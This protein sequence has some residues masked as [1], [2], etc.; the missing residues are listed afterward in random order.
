MITLSW[1]YKN[2]RYTSKILARCPLCGK[3]SVIKLP[4]EILAEQPD[5]TTHVC[6][7]MAGGC[8]H[9]FDVAPATRQTR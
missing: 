9:G 2:A 8:N 4:K 1:T 3:R 5:S 6:H 7:L